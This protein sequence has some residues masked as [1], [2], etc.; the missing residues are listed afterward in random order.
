M[1]SF[2]FVDITRFK[3]VVS[4]SLV[5]YVSVVLECHHDVTCT[6]SVIF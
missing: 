6:V 2:C 1:A 5:V 4:V 3:I